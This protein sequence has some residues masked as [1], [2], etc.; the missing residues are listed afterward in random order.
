MEE[1]KLLIGDFLKNAGLVGLKYLLDASDAEEE[2]DYGI[3][4]DKQGLWLE[5][6]FVVNA[7]W[8]DMYFKAFVKRYGELT[9]YQVILDKIGDILEKAGQPEWDKKACKEDLKF[10]NEKM[11]SNSY[12][13]GFA[14]MKDQIENPDVYELLKSHKLKENME[15]E[16]LCARLRQLTIF[17]SSHCAKR[18]FP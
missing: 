8:T 16:E 18:L 7:D 3:T 11:L 17:C 9:N 2:I 6:Q 14:N 4:E 13:S 5:R 12:Q 10:I 1:I 15:K